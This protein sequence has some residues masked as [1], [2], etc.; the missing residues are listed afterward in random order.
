MKYFFFF[1]IGL[2]F[3]SACQQESEQQMLSNIEIKEAAIFND[4]T[5]KV[6]IQAAHEYIQACEDFANKYSKHE[7]SPVLL[8]KA[9]ETARSIRSF[10]TALS[11]YKQI[12]TH[13]PEHEKAA[14]AL[15]LQAFTLDNDLQKLEEARKLYNLFL[16]KYPEDDFADD[17]KFLLENLGKSD[18]EILK[19]I[20]VG[21]EE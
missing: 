21:E 6:D 8:H 10:D 18:E 13:Y 3:I 1:S 9:G 20:G 7:K 15:F 17:T 2:F 19:N 12:T 16:E 14:Q 4:S 11:L 5:N